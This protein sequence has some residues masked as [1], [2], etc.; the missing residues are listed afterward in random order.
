MNLYDILRPMFVRSHD[1]DR[2]CEATYILK[3]EVLG[4][5]ALRQG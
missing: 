3:S 2:L 1:I 4:D 5:Q